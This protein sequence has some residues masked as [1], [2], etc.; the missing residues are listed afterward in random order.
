MLTASSS[1]SCGRLVLPRLAA[2]GAGL[3]SSL[4][5]RPPPPILVSSRSSC[6]SSHLRVSDQTHAL[7]RELSNPAS[8]HIILETERRPAAADAEGG[9][10]RRG[11]AHAPPLLDKPAWT[12]GE[13]VLFTAS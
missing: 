5:S 3:P 11:G 8:A 9:E 4:T 6:C 7:L 10:H 12:S 13:Q 1:R 2:C